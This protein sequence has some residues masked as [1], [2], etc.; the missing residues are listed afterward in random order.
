MNIILDAILTKNF[1]NVITALLKVVGEI[2]D[3]IKNCINNPPPTLH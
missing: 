3:P 2:V 1:D